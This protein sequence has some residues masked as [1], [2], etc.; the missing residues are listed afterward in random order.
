[1]LSA[2]ATDRIQDLA[3]RE[4]LD[5][6]PVL[7]EAEKL[8]PELLKD[9]DGWQSLMIDYQPPNLMRLYRQVGAVRLN[10]HFFMPADDVS[11]AR[12]R[13][14]AYDENLYHPHAWASAMRILEGEYEQWVG[15]ADRRGIDAAP[16]KTQH[17]LH[18]AGD[19]YVMNDPWIWH[20]VIPRPGQAVS[21]LMV[22]FIPE[23]WDQ[24]VPKSDRHLRALNTDELNFM[25]DHF[26]KLYAAPDAGLA[27][28]TILP[29]TH[30]RM[31]A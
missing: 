9:R 24:D 25:F 18:K 31:R 28:K 14:D 23:A 12:R 21:T 17:L 26:S 13:T 6:A 16:A 15:F 3:H 20:Q 30:P 8:I 29:V 10:L 19:A 7:L 4:P 11:A 5:M 22:T 27:P 2:D 1:M